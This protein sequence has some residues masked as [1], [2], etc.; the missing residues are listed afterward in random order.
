MERKNVMT[1]ISREALGQ[2]RAMGYKEETDELSRALGRYF[3]CKCEHEALKEKSESDNTKLQNAERDAYN[4]LLDI[5]DL[6]RKSN[7][8]PVLHGAD[9]MSKNRGLG[10]CIEFAE[11]MYRV[12]KEESYTK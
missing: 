3:M 11:A 4:A 5:C 7:T 8:K 1:E 12:S 2:L 6:S 9:N 10:L